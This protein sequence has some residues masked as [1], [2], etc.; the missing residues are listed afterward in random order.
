MRELQYIYV[1]VYMCIYAH[2]SGGGVSLITAHAR[3]KRTGSGD[4][5]IY[6]H[7]LF[8]HTCVGCNIYLCICVY[9]C[10][11]EWVAL[12]ITHARAI[13]APVSV[14]YRYMLA[15]VIY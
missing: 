7:I 11:H 15:L 6:I 4:V 8:I 10:P 13:S 2:M 9:S 1:Y 3:N 14:M 5:Y 12:I